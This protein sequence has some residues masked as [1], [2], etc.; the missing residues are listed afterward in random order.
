MNYFG[1]ILKPDKIT[2]AEAGEM[3][4]KSLSKMYLDGRFLGG[5]KHTIDNLTYIDTNEGD[6]HFFWGKEW[7]NR[8]SEMV[9]ELFYHGGILHDR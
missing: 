7:I 2:S 5:F 8:H 1:H 4:K 9:Y 3:I 6:V